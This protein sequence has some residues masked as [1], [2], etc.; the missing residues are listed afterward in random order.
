MCSDVT[1]N[2]RS[3]ASEHQRPLPSIAAS[4][5]RSRISSTLPAFTIP[6]PDSRMS[7]TL[8]ANSSSRKLS[9]PGT[10]RRGARRKEL[11][12]R[13]HGGRQAGR[14][15]QQRSGK[16]E[17]VLRVVPIDIS[18]GNGNSSCQHDG[19]TVSGIE[20]HST[21]KLADDDDS[22]SALWQFQRTAWIR[23]GK[24]F[25]KSGKRSD[26]KTTIDAHSDTN[27]ECAQQVCKPTFVDTTLTCVYCI[28]SIS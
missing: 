2:E 25:R 20:S 6:V 8:P 19:P 16:R 24:Y 17:L 1:H 26:S 9:M 28:N 18:D 14:P 10:A 13:D 22:D 11:S 3:R 27:N 12:R 21:T 5:P 7:S 15:K 23:Q 4:V